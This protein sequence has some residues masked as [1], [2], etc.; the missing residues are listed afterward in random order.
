MVGFERKLPMV[1]EE[2]KVQVNFNT[3]LIN[4]VL[5]K[6]DT[7]SSIIVDQA[8]ID[9]ELAKLFPIQTQDEVWKFEEKLKEEEMANEMVNIYIFMNFKGIKGQFKS[10]F[11]SNF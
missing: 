7:G 4:A 6:N 11:P 9:G 5:I 3:K 1:M 10:F 8:K 2:V